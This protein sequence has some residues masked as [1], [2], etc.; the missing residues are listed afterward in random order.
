MN[1]IQSRPADLAPPPGSFMVSLRATDTGGRANAHHYI[2]DG[3]G[4]PTSVVVGAGLLPKN[5]DGRSSL[6]L[7]LDRDGFSRWREFLTSYGGLP[8]SNIYLRAGEPVPPGVWL[9][10]D[11]SGS[12]L[13]GYDRQ[14]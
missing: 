2:E 6:K 8:G 14:A 3:W 12:W 10:R 1:I 7:E 13:E 9:L 5:W 4:F 11:I